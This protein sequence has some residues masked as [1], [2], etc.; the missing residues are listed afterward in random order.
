MRGVN[1]ACV[2]TDV[3]PGW[4]DTG[5]DDDLTDE[6]DYDD[7]GYYRQIPMDLRHTSTSKPAAKG[8]KAP[9]GGGVDDDDGPPPLLDCS[10]SEDEDDMPALD[11]SSDDDESDDDYLGRRPV[12]SLLAS[13]SL[14]L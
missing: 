8:A 12:S 9:A 7:D 10:S 6:E 5:N 2:R 14:R 3:K 13:L 11:D 1:C 4:H